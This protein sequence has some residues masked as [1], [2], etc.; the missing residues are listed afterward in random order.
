MEF[1]EAWDNTCSTLGLASRNGDIKTL[2]TLLRAGLTVDVQ[3]NRGW[4]PIHDA[5]GSNHAS[6]LKL[7]LKRSE[8]TVNEIEGIMKGIFC[9]LRLE[10]CVRYRRERYKL[11]NI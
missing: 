10:Y 8:L 6:C 5:A 11:E 4:R 3:D 1:S 9:F 2:R 7:V